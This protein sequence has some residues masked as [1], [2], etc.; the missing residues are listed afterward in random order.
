MKTWGIILFFSF[1]M[2][3]SGLARTCFDEGFL[4]ENLIR[5]PVNSVIANQM[6]QDR[7]D[8]ILD[9]IEDP[10]GRAAQTYLANLSPLLRT[11]VLSYAP[12]LSNIERL[13]TN[14]PR[15]WQ[16]YVF[17]D[18]VTTRLAQAIHG[19]S[20]GVRGAAWLFGK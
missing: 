2:I 7:F 1:F 5:I 20:S 3:N 4:P 16:P 12:G 11:L 10:L 9:A 8:K 15:L 19:D 13:Y 6:T 14:V 18:A 17:S